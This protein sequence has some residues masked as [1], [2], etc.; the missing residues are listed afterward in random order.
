MALLDKLFTVKETAELLH[1]SDSRIRQIC[2]EN[3]IG[4][5]VGRD[6]FLTSE[7]IDSIRGHQMPIGR[8]KK[9]SNASVDE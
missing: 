4:E 7:D 1:L 5:K 9:N 3:G 8:P 6:R 2:L